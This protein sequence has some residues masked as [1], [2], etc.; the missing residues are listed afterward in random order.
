MTCKCGKEFTARYYNGILK[1]KYCPACNYAK[2]SHKVPS[3]TNKPKKKRTQTQCAINTAD[4]WYSKYIRLLYSVDGK[5]QCYT[6]GN[7]HNIKQMDCG[8]W[9]RRAFNATRY[10]VNNARPQD[11]YCNK[12]RSGQ[13]EI[14]EAELIIEIGQEEVNELKRLALDS[15]N[16]VYPESFFREQAEKYRL[17]FNDL[18]KVKGDPWG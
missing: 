14:F 8:H 13:P 4:N 1:S 11:T 3:K 15:K 2:I 10:H 16:N 5:A 6:C 7:W 17:L 18:K 9:Q 12:Y